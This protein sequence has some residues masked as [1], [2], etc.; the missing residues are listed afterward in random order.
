MKEEMFFSSL[1]DEAVVVQDPAQGHTTRERQLRSELK[2]FPR[3][4][5]GLY[6][7]AEPDMSPLSC[8]LLLP[9]H[10]AWCL[11]LGV[12]YERM[13]TL[14]A[15]KSTPNYNSCSLTKS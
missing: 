1:M 3:A 4:H 15:P 13:C 8:P 12:C 9:W 7:L 14:A 5:S 2:P 10:L 6:V 11:E